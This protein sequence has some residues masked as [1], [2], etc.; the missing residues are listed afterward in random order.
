MRFGSCADISD[1]MNVG[2]GPSSSYVENGFGKKTLA[3]LL[4]ATALTGWYGCRPNDQQKAE[5]AT[6]RLIQQCN[7]IQTLES[8]RGSI[9]KMAMDV[10][11]E[12]I[13]KAFSKRYKQLLK[14][15]RNRQDWGQEAPPFEK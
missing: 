7:D 12:H 6:V 9:Y 15:G 5:K 2:S 14:K 13:D 10:D 4:A 1:F 8:L 3:T 11:K